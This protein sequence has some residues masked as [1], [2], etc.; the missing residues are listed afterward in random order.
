MARGPPRPPRRVAQLARASDER[1]QPA[2]SDQ[3]A[4]EPEETSSRRTATASL[5]DH[6]ESTKPLNR[7]ETLA[8]ASGEQTDEESP[9]DTAA[10]KA[11][12]PTTIT[13]TKKT[14]SLDESP[15]TPAPAEEMPT[16][17]ELEPMNWQQSLQRTIRGIED[18]LAN[19]RM[20]ETERMRMQAHLGLLNIIAEDPE[21]ATNAFQD[22]DDE[23]LEFWRQT[24]MALDAL[25]APNELPVDRIELN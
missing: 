19:E 6:D 8:V 22:L 17:S 10:E 9:D 23:E 11:T 18:R 1:G 24:T 20:S 13:A 21:K 15:P 2:E 12:P 16:Q 3:A 7:K 5:S 4:T 25:L 14:A